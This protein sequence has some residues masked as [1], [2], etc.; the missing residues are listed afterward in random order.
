MPNDVRNL[1]L[2]ISGE[3]FRQG[4]QFSRLRDTQD[5]IVPQLKAIKSHL[6][7]INHLKNNFDINTQIQILSY[8]SKGESVIIDTYTESN[9]IDYKFYED[10]FSDRTILTNSAKIDDIHR[11]DAILVI[12]PDM[13]LKDF[14]IEN[15]NPFNEKI[16]YPSVVWILNNAYFYPVFNRSYQFVPRVNDT[17][18]FIPKP[19][20]DIIYNDVGLKLYHEAILDYDKHNILLNNFDF[21]TYTMHDSDP[22][23]DYNPF[24]SFIGRPETKNWYSYGYE[25]RPYDFL[26]LETNHK[27]YFPD[28]NLLND[29][30]N[31]YDLEQLKNYNNLWEWWHHYDGYKKF[32]NI[33]ELDF[34]HYGGDLK[35]VLP[36]R[37]HFQTFYSIKDEYKLSFFDSIQR[38]TSILYKKNNEEFHGK[39]LLDND[40][41]TLK[42]ILL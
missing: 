10:Y 41:F 34:N 20:F 18:M 36:R 7:L 16:C 39:S 11:Y 40:E 19:Y 31:K 26:A 23:K 42:K 28:W 12:R 22:F 21:F 5:S 1:L 2:I 37:H 33:I 24:Y 6:K 9:V 15:F 3:F 17:M 13:F 8:K 27:H 32:I 30:I 35:L 4:G 14:F 38:L 25:V 29:G